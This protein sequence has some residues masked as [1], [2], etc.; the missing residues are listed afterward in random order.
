MQTYFAPWNHNVRF[1]ATTIIY[2][3]ELCRAVG[4]MPHNSPTLALEQVQQLPEPLK[5]KALLAANNAEHTWAQMIEFKQHGT[6]DEHPLLPALESGNFEYF[7]LLGGRAG[8]KSHEIAEAIVELCSKTPKRVVCGREFQNSIDQSARSLLV[9]KIKQHPSADEWE[10]LE[11]EL[12][13]SNGTLI[14]FIGLARNPESAKSLEGADLFWGEEAQTFSATS[15]EI[16]TPTIRESGSMLIFSLNPR[17]EDDPVY[18]LAMVD[19]P[20]YAFVKVS[21]FEDNPFLFT[22]RL[23][24]DLR[25]SF[26]TSNRYKHVWRGDLDSNSELLILPHTIGRPPIL[27]NLYYM[28]RRYYGI[29][30]GGTDPTALVRL[31][32]YP[33]EAFGRDSDDR[34][35]LYFDK[36]FVRPC[37]SNRDIVEGVIDTCPELLEQKWHVQADS[38]DPKAIGELNNA[39]I[40]TIGAEKGP[41][42]VLA[43]IRKLQDFDIYVEPDCKIISQCIAKYR[44]KTDKAGNPTNVPEHQFSH[45]FDAARYAIEGEDFSYDGGVSYIIIGEA[46]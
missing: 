44:W 3:M 36:E 30:F 35:V 14:T 21:G 41:G 13:H 33:P 6:H 24:N 25:K 15:L 19:K 8:G 4:L 37:R 2:H 27:K 32:H 17:F 23:A 11:R 46:S 29:D 31:W 42:S 43:G 34:G 16:L 9:K 18:Q 5:N 12:R 26:K 38:A 1:P 22:S 10:C 28:G 40:P 7:F 39:G 20:D 45:P